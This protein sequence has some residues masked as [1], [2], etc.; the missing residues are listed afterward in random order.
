MIPERFR[1]F[2]DLG[3]LPCAGGSAIRQG[4]LFRAPALCAVSAEERAFLEALSLDTVIDFRCAEEIAERG[5]SP[6]PGSRYINAPMFDEKKYRYIVVSKKAKLRVVLLRGRRTALLKKNKLDSYLEMPFSPALN[7]LFDAMDRGERIVFH[8]TEGKDRTGVAAALIEYA[9]GRGEEEI[10]GQYLL[11][12]RLRP[13]RDRSRL[14]YLGLPKRLIEDIVFCEQ[15]H[16]EL[17]DLAKTQ[18]L[19]RYG[20][21]EKYLER[22]FGVTPERIERWKAF[23][24]TSS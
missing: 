5:D 6:I 4:M 2:R 12:N 11:S 21:A 19:L 15:T 24:L 3:G 17:F 7:V 10:R 18:I 1:N 13:G 9:L 8:C 20:T 22:C 16:G 14:K 23:Y